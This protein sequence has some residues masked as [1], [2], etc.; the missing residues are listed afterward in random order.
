MKADVQISFTSHFE[1]TPAGVDDLRN[2]FSPDKRIM[3]QPSYRQVF[4]EKHGFISDLSIIDKL[5]NQR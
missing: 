2:S 3:D 1:K 5:F 4:T